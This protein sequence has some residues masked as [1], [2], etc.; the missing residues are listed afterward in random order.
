VDIKDRTLASSSCRARGNSAHSKMLAQ[1]FFIG[2]L[3]LVENIF[4]A[5]SQDS[6]TQFSK[7]AVTKI[8]LLAGSCYPSMI[9]II[10]QWLFFFSNLRSGSVGD[11]AQDG[12]PKFA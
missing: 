11:H 10:I 1:L 3:L 9:I 2:N 8:A 4:H 7:S 12:L 6:N 5:R